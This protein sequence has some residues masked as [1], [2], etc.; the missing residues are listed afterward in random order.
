MTV[1]NIIY[2]KHNKEIFEKLIMKR[3]VHLFID[4]ANLFAINFFKNKDLTNKHGEVTGGLFGFIRAFMKMMDMFYPDIDNVHV[5][6]D[7][8]RSARALSL[9]PEYKAN[10]DKIAKKHEE[11]DPEKAEKEKKEFSTNRQKTR[12]FIESIGVKQYLID[13]VEG[14]IIL[15]YLIMRFLKNKPKNSICVI[16]SNDSD[17]LAHK[18]DPN[19]I[20]E[21]YLLFDYFVT[22]EYGC[23]VKEFEAN[24]SFHVLWNTVINSRSPGPNDSQIT[25]HTVRASVQNDKYP[26]ALA[27]DEVGLYAEWQPGRDIP[28]E[29]ELPG[30]TYRVRMILTEESFHQSGLGGYWASAMG[31]DTLNFTIIPR[32]FSDIEPALISSPLMFNEG[33]SDPGDGRTVEINLNSLNGS[34]NITVVQTNMYNPDAPGTN[35]FN[36]KIDI[37]TDPGIHSFSG[38]LTLHYKDSDVLCYPENSSYLGIA[39][40]DQSLNCWSWL[41]GSINPSSNLITISGLDSFSSYM[42]CGRRFGDIT[43]YGY[44]DAADLQ[45]LG[46]VWHQTNSGEFPRDSDEH[47]FN[48]NKT[49]NEQGNQIINSGDLQVFQDNWHNQAL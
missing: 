5:V 31:T 46:D 43:G 4:G 36:F 45:K 39:K 16:I 42:I 17:F 3:E 32:V 2:N 18:N 13:N 19:Y 27:P 44:V 47:F 1:N 9:D 14:D 28:G 24:N 33:G 10:R 30:S 37:T 34:G 15:S 49:A 23:A 48:Y 7:K 40:F 12:E 29:A 22:D 26:N 38:D 41:G 35:V 6:W 11:L 20:F 25:Y 21:G 8:G